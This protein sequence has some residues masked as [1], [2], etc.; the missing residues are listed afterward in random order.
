VLE[1]E[2]DVPLDY[3]VAASFMMQR[4][5]LGDPTARM[6]RGRFVKAGRTPEGPA[7]VE[8]VHERARARVRVRAWGEGGAWALARAGAWLGAADL[9]WTPPPGRVAELA[10]RARGVRLPR[11]PFPGDVYTGV[12]LQQRVTFAEAARSRFAIVDRYGEDAP[13]PFGLRLFP[14]AR[15]VTGIPSYALMEMGVE[16]KRAV[17]LREA[18]RIGARLA[19]ME[20]AP[21][22]D[23]RK[24]LMAVPGTGAWTAENVLGYALGDA[25]AVPTGDAHLPHAVSFALADEPFTSDARMLELLEPYRGQRFRVLR[26]ILLAG[27]TK[28]TIDRGRSPPRRRRLG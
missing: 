2:L 23:I 25:D 7:T 3:D 22:A 17:A 26:W 24:L 19:T 6:E 14:D 21:F 4:I 16:S 15:T 20:G 9:G 10:R 12:V 5:G 1:A 11:S 13:G 27:P 28:P 8:L 18:A